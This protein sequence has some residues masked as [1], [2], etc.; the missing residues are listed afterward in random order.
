MSHNGVHPNKLGYVISNH[1]AIIVE[2]WVKEISSLP[3][4]KDDPS[5]FEK[6][7]LPASATVV[8]FVEY[9][10]NP[11]NL[12]LI[13]YTST[14]FF[15]SCAAQPV[16]VIAII[17]KGRIVVLP[18]IENDEGN[19]K[20]ELLVSL[21]NLLSDISIFLTRVL[22]DRF[23]EQL[24]QANK[25]IT[26]ITNLVHTVGSTLDLSEVL[27][28]AG[29]AMVSAVGTNHC[30]FYLVSNEMDLQVALPYNMPWPNWQMP[31]PNYRQDLEL[32]YLSNKDAVWDVL[33]EKVPVKI[34]DAQN[35]PRT[36]HVEDIRTFGIKSF[37]LIPCL[38]KG[39][40]IAVAVITI[41]DRN[42]IFSP[43]EV[44]LT[45]TIGNIIAPA[46]EN[47]RFLQKVEQLAGL[48]ERARL[49]REMH[50]SLSQNLSAMQLKASQMGNLLQHDQIE[51]ASKNL[52]E[53]NLIAKEAYTDVREAIFHLRSQPPS[54]KGYLPF[55]RDFL[56]TY[57]TCFHIPVNL[58]VENDPTANL[59]ENMGTHIFYIIQEALT[60]IRKHAHASNI[61][62]G[63]KQVSYTIQVEIKD[64]GIGF[65]P[66]LLTEDQK[67][68]HFGLQIMQE[69]AEEIGG[70]I[71]VE[72]QPDHGTLVR[73]VAP[74]TMAKLEKA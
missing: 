4:F 3:I 69:R 5:S 36:S 40:V 63:I 68:R 16:D 12:S 60:N 23:T 18:F 48:E 1:K 45:W 24:E 14:N 26:L 8:A 38:S 64:N 35:D 28:E 71:T 33:R 27:S 54:G 56:T 15:L 52:K 31:N 2:N 30:F 29:K 70:T 22:M 59:T 42:R 74:I 10:I 37:L 20:I 61:K 58:I 7:R 55:I 49:A 11:S 6:L 19:E 34:Y 13:Q 53:L 66:M 65:D 9:L 25:R 67:K 32:G 41:F 46:I 50:D 72:S 21:D 73:L 51:L 47:A 57:Q 43:E 39:Q 44:E 17:Q 62:I